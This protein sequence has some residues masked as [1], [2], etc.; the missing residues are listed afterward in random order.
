MKKTIIMFFAL[1]ISAMA[2]CQEKFNPTIGSEIVYK[3]PKYVEPTWGEG[4]YELCPKDQ[5]LRITDEMR[6]VQLVEKLADAYNVLM[7]FHS[8]YSD[9]ECHERHE[10]NTAKG[11]QKMN[12]SV[13]KDEYSRKCADEFRNNIAK[14][15]KHKSVDVE[16]PIN[17]YLGEMVDIYSLEKLT[18]NDDIFSE[19]DYETAINHDSLRI[20]PFSRCCVEAIELAHDTVDGLPNEDALP[21]LVEVLTAG[22]YSPL[23]L[24]AW[25]TWR[26][27]IANKM[28]HSKD[29]YIPN[30]EYNRLRMIAGYTTLCHIK[31]YPADWVAVNNFLLMASTPNVAIF[32]QYPFGNQS[33]MFFYEMFPELC[34]DLSDEE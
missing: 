29:S 14:S 18:S 20:D 19:D 9:Y 33:V 2:Y 28:G 25:K 12:T 1:A 22:Q 4:D 8:V 31:D 23:L 10:V 34:P 5:W 32:G 15:Q 16:E 3:V 6:N 7:V 26:A 11:M 13:I 21:K 24:E 27:M 30:E 17:K